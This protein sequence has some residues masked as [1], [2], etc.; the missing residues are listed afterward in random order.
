MADPL[1]APPRVSS[2]GPPGDPRPVRRRGVGPSGRHLQVDRDAPLRDPRR[3][4]GHRARARREARG[5]AGTAITTPGTPS[6]WDKRLPEL[7]EMKHE[8]SPDRAGQRR[9]ERVHGVDSASPRRR[10]RRSRSWWAS[11]GCYPPEDRGVHVP[12]ERDEPDHRRAD[13]TV[14]RLHPPGRARRLDRGR[15]APPVAHRDRR[16]GRPARHGARSSS[17][18][19]C[20]GRAGSPAGYAG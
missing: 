9:D 8:Q 2:V 6:W 18:R 20:C 3:L 1:K 13:A 17:R 15:D 4:G 5:S 10:I 7:R 19:S 11:T 14:A 12:P 16:R